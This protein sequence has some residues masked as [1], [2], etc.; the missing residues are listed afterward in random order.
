[1]EGGRGGHIADKFVQSS[2]RIASNS[3]IVERFIAGV[4]IFVCSNAVL[5]LRG[6]LWQKAWHV[7]RQRLFIVTTLCGNSRQHSKISFVPSRNS[8]VTLAMK[9]E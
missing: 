1:M 2:K 7:K 5:Q 6:F 3:C 8:V 9:V 4:S